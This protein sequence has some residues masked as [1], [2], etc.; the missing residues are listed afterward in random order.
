MDTHLPQLGHRPGAVR[1]DGVGHGDHAQQGPVTSKEQGR[2]APAGQVLRL[3][4]SLS[5]D[6]RLLRQEPQAAAHQSLAAQLGGQAVA[7]QG[8]KVLRLRRGAALLL[9]LCQD[10]PG[11]GVLAAGLQGQGGVHQLILC[12]AGGG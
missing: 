5:R 6:V 10:G 7:G 12:H 3:P 4:L 11:Q 8:G 9:A 2:L 1:L